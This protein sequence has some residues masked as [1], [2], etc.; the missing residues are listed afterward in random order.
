MSPTNKKVVAKKPKKD[1]DKK[2]RTCLPLDQRLEIVRL[3]ENGSTF[4]QIA[5]DK[6]TNESSIRTI[7]K[8]RDDIKRQGIQTAKFDAKTIVWKKSTAKLEMEQLLLIWVEDCA[9]R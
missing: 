8:N 6:K 4:A 9:K 3:R 1:V 5:R 2:K 7:W